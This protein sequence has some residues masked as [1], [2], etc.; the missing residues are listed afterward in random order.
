MVNA[1]LVAAK[2]GE[3]VARIA[4]VRARVPGTPEELRADKDAL[5]LV[6]FNLMLCVQSAADIASHLVADEGWRP[7]LTL[8]GVF[9]R[10]AENGVIASRTA[11]AMGRA[12]GLR[13]VIAHGYAGVDVAIVFAAASGGVDDLHAFAAE[14]AA[15]V[16]R[17]PAHRGA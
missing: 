16:R 13:N 7:S 12:A 8:A 1:D 6:A 10:L 14:V 9:D 3:L 17:T 5:D 2:L 15:W 11:D 4:R